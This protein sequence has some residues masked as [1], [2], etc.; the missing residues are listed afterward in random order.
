MSVRPSPPLAGDA[1]PLSASL[2]ESAARHGAHTVRAIA[3]DRVELLSIATSVEN[4]A[5]INSPDRAIAG[6]CAIQQLGH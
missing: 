1:D 6:R 4:R 3:P 5:E 2:S